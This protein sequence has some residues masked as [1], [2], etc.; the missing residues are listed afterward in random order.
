MCDLMDDLDVYD[1]DDCECDC[2]YCG[3]AVNLTDI[4]VNGRVCDACR[5]A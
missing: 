1:K 5:R 2:L 3:G 4:T